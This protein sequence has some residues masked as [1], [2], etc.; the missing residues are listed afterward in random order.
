MS[1]HAYQ[2]TCVAGFANGWCE[3]DFISEYS[4]ECTVFESSVHALHGGNCDVDVDEC[5]SG[6][7]QHDAL[8]SD[9]AGVITSG[10]LTGV[11]D[12]LNHSVLVAAHAYRC[13]C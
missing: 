1:L 6:P 11:R 3:Y 9:S 12:Q 7:C 10:N 8:C 13:S 4:E 5:V 2:C